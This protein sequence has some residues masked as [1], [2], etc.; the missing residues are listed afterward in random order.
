[1]KSFLYLLKEDACSE[2]HL[3][4]PSDYKKLLERE[5]EKD[6]SQ[7]G[8]QAYSFHWKEKTPDGGLPFGE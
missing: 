6:F 2:A 5:Q 3:V 8:S 1:L 4:S 7:L